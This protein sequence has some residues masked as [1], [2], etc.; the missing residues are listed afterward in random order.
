MIQDDQRKSSIWR[1][2]VAFEGLGARRSESVSSSEAETR[3][4]AEG[5]GANFSGWGIPGAER[6]ELPVACTYYGVVVAD[7]PV[8]TPT[9]FCDP[10]VI[11]RLL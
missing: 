11:E 8:I 3:P 10:V 4:R 1:S 6:L 5:C 9:G 7:L 2:R